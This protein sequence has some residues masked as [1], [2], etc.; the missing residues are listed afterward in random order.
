VVAGVRPED[1]VIGHASSSTSG[2]IVVIEPQGDERIVS[3]SL[4]GVPNSAIWKS[5]APR[6][7]DGTEYEV[8]QAVT[9]TVRHGGLRLFNGTSGSRIV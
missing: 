5:R 4:D 7:V 2:T 3:I 1:L 9:L 8:G 6:P